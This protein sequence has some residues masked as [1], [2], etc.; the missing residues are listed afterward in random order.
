MRGRYDRNSGSRVGAFA[1]LGEHRADPLGGPT[2]AL[3]LQ[4]I[5]IVAATGDS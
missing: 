1:L 2:S 5:L 4:I 3:L